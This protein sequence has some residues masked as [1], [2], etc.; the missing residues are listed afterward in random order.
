MC[1][2]AFTTI[3]VVLRREH[4]DYSLTRCRVESEPS[5]RNDISGGAWVIGV[6]GRPLLV[7]LTVDVHRLVLTQT[8]QRRRRLRR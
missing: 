6:V 1:R 2:Q 8:K 4:G 5:T 7:D 3:N